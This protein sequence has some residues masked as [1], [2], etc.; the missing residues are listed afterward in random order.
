MRGSW[1]ETLELGARSPSELLAFGHSGP[2]ALIPAWIDVLMARGD[3]G[4][5]RGLDPTEDGSPFLESG[6]HEGTPAS[7][8]GSL[9]DSV[10]Q[11][12]VS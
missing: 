4:P 8:G 7:L 10:T 3:A 2:L 9:W 12:M 5:T 11:H 6:S 1:Y